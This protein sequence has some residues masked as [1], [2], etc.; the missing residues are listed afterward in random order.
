MG[1]LWLELQFPLK[2]TPM[3]GIFSSCLYVINSP[4]YI[5]QTSNNVAIY[6]QDSRAEY[7]SNFINEL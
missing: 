3:F 5:W 1:I 7:I 6:L 2:E 4:T